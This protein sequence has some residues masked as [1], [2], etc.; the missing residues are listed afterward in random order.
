VVRR[1]QEVEASGVLSRRALA[2]AALA[3]ALVSSASASVHE[4]TWGDSDD[5]DPRHARLS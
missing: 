5:A 4:F 1:E 3:L 2:A